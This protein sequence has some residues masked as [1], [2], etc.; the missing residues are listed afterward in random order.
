MRR[1]RSRTRQH[2]STFDF[3]AL[4]AAQQYAD[5][6]ARLAFIQDFAEHLDARHDRLRGVAEAHDLDFLADLDLAALDAPGYHSPAPRD[7]ENVFDR[8]KERLVGFARWLRHVAV[9]RVHQIQDGLTV[10]A[11]VPAPSA[12]AR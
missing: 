7:R 5:I 3:F 2:L 10:L 9:D 6:V 8:H 12:L 4:N 11:G 1:D